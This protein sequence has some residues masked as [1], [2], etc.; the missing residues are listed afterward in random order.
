MGSSNWTWA[1]KT[2]TITKPILRQLLTGGSIFWQF[3]CFVHLTYLV[4]KCHELSYHVMKYFATSYDNSWWIVAVDVPFCRPLADFADS[5]TMWDKRTLPLFYYHVRLLA[6]NGIIG[7]LK[8]R[9]LRHMPDCPY[10]GH[11]S[12]SLSLSLP[13]FLSFWLPLLLLSSVARFCRLIS[14]FLPLYIYIFIDIHIHIY[15]YL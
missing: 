8:S 4:I 12:L 10:T 9:T 7:K 1:K 15:I 2:S 11:L 6:G 13:Q 14:F 5:H 3:D